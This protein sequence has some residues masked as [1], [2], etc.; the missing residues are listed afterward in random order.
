MPYTPE[1]E[2]K[3]EPAAAVV[4]AALVAEMDGRSTGV[5]GKE[6]VQV[7]REMLGQF[8]AVGGGGGAAAAAASPRPREAGEAQG[9][10]QHGAAAAPSQRETST[11]AHEW[12]EELARKH[13]EMLGHALPAA[14]RNASKDVREAGVSLVEELLLRGS[15]LIVQACMPTLALALAALRVDRQESTGTC[16]PVAVSALLLALRRCRPHRLEQVMEECKRTCARLLSSLPKT[17]A[18]EADDKIKADGLCGLLGTL[19][20]LQDCGMLQDVMRGEREEH[21]IASIV[22]CFAVSCRGVLVEATATGPAALRYTA[23]AAAYQHDHLQQT[24]QRLQQARQ[25]P[26]N[27][28]N[29]EDEQGEEEEEEEEEKEEWGEE[30]GV[31]RHSG[32]KVWRR[33]RQRVR[34]VARSCQRPLAPPQAARVSPPPPHPCRQDTRWSGHK[35]SATPSQAASPEEGSRRGKEEEGSREERGRR[36]REEPECGES[37]GGVGSQECGHKTSRML[38]SEA[39]PHV[40][41]YHVG[42][43]SLMEEMLGAILLVLAQSSG[44]YRLVKVSASSSSSSTP[45]PRSLTSRLVLLASSSPSSRS[46]CHLTQPPL[47]QRERGE[48]GGVWWGGSRER[49]SER[50]MPESM[51]V[52]VFVLDVPCQQGFIC[53]RGRTAKT[54]VCIQ[55]TNVL[56]PTETIQVFGQE[57]SSGAGGREV[58][59]QLDGSRRATLVLL[60]NKLISCYASSCHQ[61]APDLPWVSDDGGGWSKRS[62]KGPYVS[63]PPAAC[64]LASPTAQTILPTEGLADLPPLWEEEAAAVAGGCLSSGLVLRLPPPLVPSCA[65]SSTSTSASSLPPHATPPARAGG[66]REMPPRYGRGNGSLAMSQL[67]ASLDYLLDIYLDMLEAY[68]VAQGME[69]GG[70]GGGG[71]GGNASRPLAAARNEQLCACL[72]TQGVADLAEAVGA[73][74]DG[75]LLRAAYPLLAAAA[76]PSSA[77]AAAALASLHRIRRACSYSSLRCVSCALRLSC[78]DKLAR[79]ASECGGELSTD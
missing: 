38:H 12:L 60:I 46:H 44:L 76:S 56:H 2:D 59:G 70:G 74:F 45:T 28:T 13:G 10:A 1:E 25:R 50:E 63:W 42:N 49:A 15:R 19:L 62:N 4:A 36:G 71:G 22:K 26:C 43:A 58:E 67:L 7:L 35:A 32:G 27:S 69:A 53:S 30:G 77:L 73:S 11:V 72:V 57:L 66:N 54:N 48:G 33:V 41:F 34:Q 52:T 31:T 68:L 6:S 14:M 47:C 61:L 21:A 37:V 65:A 78:L 23:I 51:R 55:S 40:T 3:E 18:S 79:N 75:K 64:G 9:K 17:F 29:H 16:A 8:P 24:P 20:L 5:K 39:Y